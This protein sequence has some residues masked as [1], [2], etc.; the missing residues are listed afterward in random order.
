MP[1]KKT[2]KKP[3]VKKVIPEEKVE[4]VHKDLEKK[5]NSYLKKIF[6]KSEDLNEI[7]QKASLFLNDKKSKTKESM[8]EIEELVKKHPS[9]S[10][11]VAALAGMGLG[12]LLNSKK[13]KK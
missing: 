5:L 2:T 1:A 11:V 6:G 9:T 13:K 3:E 12:S 10:L 7:K 8:K 4:K